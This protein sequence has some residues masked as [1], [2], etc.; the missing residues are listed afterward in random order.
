MPQNKKTAL[1]NTTHLLARSGSTRLADLGP[2]QV[3]TLLKNLVAS[4]AL[5]TEEAQT[6]VQ[7]INIIQGMVM[8]YRPLKDQQPA[9][10]ATGDEATFKV[11]LPIAMTNPA[12]GDIQPRDVIFV[13]IDGKWYLKSRI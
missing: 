10:N 13:K 4:H 1:E 8:E 7:A 2:I 6:M 3:E 9:M 11:I 5:T 12:L